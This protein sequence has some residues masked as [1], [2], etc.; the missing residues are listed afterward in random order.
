MGGDWAADDTVR[1]GGR[2]MQVIDS[3]WR[4]W[5]WTTDHGIG[6]GGIRGGQEP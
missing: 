1:G 3:Y 2:T 5:Q 4:Q 6:R